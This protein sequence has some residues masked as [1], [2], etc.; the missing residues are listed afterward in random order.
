MVGELDQDALHDMLAGNAD[1]FRQVVDH[2]LGP[3]SNYVNRMIRDKAA[4][5]DIIQET[6][7]KLWFKRASFDPA[8]AQLTTW[9][10]RIAHN[11]CVDHHRKSRPVMEPDEYLTDANADPFRDYALASQASRVQSALMA[12]PE[13]QRSAIVMYHYQGLAN[14]QIAEILDLSLAAL[15]SLLRRSRAK[16]KVLLE[17]DDGN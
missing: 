4:A 6:F 1:A 2:Q 7:A 14:W 17:K 11:L 15:E 3:I 5:E 16:L 12:L 13:R 10:H 9:L 8:R